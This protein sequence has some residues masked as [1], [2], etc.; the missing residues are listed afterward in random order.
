MRLILTSVLEFGRYKGERVDYILRTNPSY[1]LW[2]RENT[3][4]LTSA[5]VYQLAKQLNSIKIKKNAKEYNPSAHNWE[6]N[7]FTR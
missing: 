1:I 3:S 4:V 7:G 6:L 2:L 5:K